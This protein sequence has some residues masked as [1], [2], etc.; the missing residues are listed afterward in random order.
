M[1][2]RQVRS[3][4][5]HRKTEHAEIFAEA[6]AY[7][8]EAI[9]DKL[10]GLL[11]GGT[12][13]VHVSVEIR[14][15]DLRSWREDVLERDGHR[16]VDCGRTERLHAHHLQERSKRPDLALDVDNGVTV[17]DDCHAERHEPRLRGLI[18]GQHGG[19]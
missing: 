10:P 13:V 4:N 1:A 2:R 8:A 15:P 12:V 11:P 14:N 5:P 16:C 6:V 18:R 17:C 19:R 7:A 3:I 9:A